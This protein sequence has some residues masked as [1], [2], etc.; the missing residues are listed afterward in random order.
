MVRNTSGPIYEVAPV[1]N[2]RNGDKIVLSDG[3]YQSQ[4][5]SELRGN[6][7]NSVYDTKVMEI[8][9]KLRDYFPELRIV[10]NYDTKYNLSIRVPL[11]IRMDGFDFTTFVRHREDN[12]MIYL[13]DRNTKLAFSYYETAEMDIMDAY[14]LY[15]WAY[16]IPDEN[17]GRPL[18]M[19]ALS[20]YTIIGL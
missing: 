14:G 7:N 11:C 20:N 18:S 8:L 4:S 2:T 13:Y 19:S 15:D 6:L 3:A 16:S 1:L 10:K 9:P 17:A 12:G 5:D